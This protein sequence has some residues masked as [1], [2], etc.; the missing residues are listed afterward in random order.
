MPLP[1]PPAEL[2]LALS[3]V[4]ADLRVSWYIFGAQAVMYWGRPR[5]TEDIDVTVQLGSVEIGRL[6]S[7]LQ[8]AGFALRQ[9][10]TPA[11]IDRTRV[12]PLLFG[13]SGWALDIVLGGPGLEEDFVR[14]AIA[15]EVAPGV[16]VPII[17]AEDLI[18]TKVLAGRPK[19]LDDVRGV[20]LAQAGSLDLV[21]ARGTLEMLEDALGVSDLIPVFDH[22]VN[23]DR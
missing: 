23:T 5:L 17:S 22:L 16:T 3:K 14:R 9:E 21:A 11:F 20:L 12:V 19:D 2:L 1:A 7:E 8:R 10:G 13:D 15:V 18:V 4:L 6:I